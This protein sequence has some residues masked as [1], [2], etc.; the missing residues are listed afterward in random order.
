MKTNVVEDTSIE[1]IAQSRV[2]RTS[3]VA[4]PPST[5]ESWLDICM[6]E[7]KAPAADEFMVERVFVG[8]KQAEFLLA[9]N[10]ENNRHLSDEHLVKLTKYLGSGHWKFRADVIKLS[11]SGWLID[12]QHRCKAIIKAGVP[13]DTLVC[14]GL[15][16]SLIRE[17]DTN[18]RPRSYADGLRVE[19]A[20]YANRLS[21]A[22]AVLKAIETEEFSSRKRPTNFEL[23][24]MLAA[25]AAGLQWAVQEVPQ[26]I[27]PG[28]QAGAKE[29]Y[30]AFAYLY[31]IAPE[32]IARLKEEYVNEGAPA[33]HPMNTLRRAI[34][35]FPKE[36]PRV[37]LMKVLRCLEAGIKGEELKIARPDESIFRRV[38]ELRQNHEKMQE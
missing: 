18:I 17:L 30:S 20:K 2:Q 35:N 7:D 27:E 5:R 1:E 13:A 28:I 36:S 37:R 23:D 31:P 29:I 11:R 3:D 25:H 14:Y 4:P 16:D 10:A 6:R 33:G 32:R 26:K 34:T 12:G 24:E 21:A 22:A 9:R 15:D 19:G 38:K 8:V